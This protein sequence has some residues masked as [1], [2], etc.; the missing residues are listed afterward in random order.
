MTR[1]TYLIGLFGALLLHYLTLALFAAE[2]IPQQYNMP[3]HVLWFHQG[4]D[5]WGYYAQ[6]E[7][8][9]TGVF[10]PNKYP[11]GFP[12]LTLPLYTLLQPTHHNQL[13]E[14]VSAFWGVLMFPL[15]QLTLA[16]LADKL[17]GRRTIALLTV[18]LWTGLALLSWA[19]LAV[20][21]NSEMAEI[22]SVHLPW[23][24]MLSDGPATL[25]TLLAV[26]VYWLARSHDFALR[27]VLLLGAI[28]G[29]L[30][31]IRLTG[32][33]TV[34]TIGLL[35]LLERRWRPA[36][37]VGVVT[38]LV[39]SPQMIYNTVFFGSPLTSGYSVLD[40]LPPQG[41]FS[42]VYLGQALNAVWTRL[43]IWTVAALAGGVLLLG[44]LLRC[45]YRRMPLLAGL[46]I[47][48]IVPYLL[49]YSLYYYSWVGG[50]LR[51]LMPIYPAFC[52]LFAIGI[53]D[54]ITSYNFIARK[55][56]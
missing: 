9:A 14:P 29:I 24:Q 56:L 52:L 15:G 39:F 5:T 3:G 43:G 7:A 45:T 51:F 4:G 44:W 46:I 54:C 37:L 8:L 34:G 50:F 55:Q 1:R 26:L 48:W 47:L 6:M 38:M 12:L 32:A 28:L 18:W 21:W 17:T 33:L 40:E 13:V 10:Q 2:I 19:V 53:L 27:W 30:M 25:F 41:L 31:L 23:V 42:P 11:L 22:I 49:L 36:L 35:L 16:Y 20:I